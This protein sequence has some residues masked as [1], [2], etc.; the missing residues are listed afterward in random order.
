MHV[1]L[2]EL[3]NLVMVKVDV[4]VLVFDYY[5]AVISDFPAAALSCFLL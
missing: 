1:G 5:I 2:V 3:M 4:V